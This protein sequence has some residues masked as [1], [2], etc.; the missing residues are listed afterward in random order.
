MKGG[1]YRACLLY[2]L[3]AL[4]LVCEF[5]SV[6]AKKTKTPPKPKPRVRREWRTLSVAMRQRV[7]NAFWVLKNTTTQQGRLLYGANFN[8]HDEML[9]LHTC[10]V[11]DPRCDNGHFGPQFMTFHRAFLLK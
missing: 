7:A 6:E 3:L 5:S 8:N 2:L 10:A 4:L 1:L 11:Y 9:L